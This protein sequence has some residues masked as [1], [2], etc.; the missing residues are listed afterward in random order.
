MI[1]KKPIRILSIDGGGIFGLVPLIILQFIEKYTQKSICD[2][3]DYI[4]GTSSGGII[5]LA[6]SC[7]DEKGKPLYS[8]SDILS[9]FQKKAPM[10]FQKSLVH[11]IL[12]HIPLLNKFYSL[13]FPKYC[14]AG[15]EKVFKNTFH[16]TTLS[17]S[18]CHT[19]V[20]TYALTKPESHLYVFS[21]PEV[22]KSVQKGKADFL[23][24]DIAFATSAAPTFFPPRYIRCLYKNAPPYTI[25]YA[26]ID[27]AVA[28]NNM[29]LFLY[30]Y[31]R[32]KHPN[33]PIHILSLGIRQKPINIKKSYC[34]RMGIVSWLKKI[35]C[36]IPH[37]Q[38]SS[39]QAVLKQLISQS[40][41]KDIY[42]RIQPPYGIFLE[43]FDNISRTH[44]QKILDV[45]KKTLQKNKDRILCFIHQKDE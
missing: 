45:G 27:G 10:I 8:T 19:F 23:I 25:P 42:E 37:S 15:A 32:K 38:T 6:L 35:T 33:R 43:E 5:A 12:C 7:P 28:M 39:H 2:F 24:R 41:H 29:S 1:S 13:F 21:S 11:K 14:E 18:L 9:L 16:N 31:A 44:M 30:A 3:F 36:F 26:F 20:S 17:Q 40:P 22:K 4:S 34:K